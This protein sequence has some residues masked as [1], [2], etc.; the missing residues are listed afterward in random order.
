MPVQW[1]ARHNGAERLFTGKKHAVPVHRLKTLPKQNNYTDCGLFL[2]AYLQYFAFSLPAKEQDLHQLLEHTTSG[3][4]PAADRALEGNLLVGQGVATLLTKCREACDVMSASNQA[5]HSQSNGIPWMQLFWHSF[6]L[7]WPHGR[8]LM[9]VCVLPRCHQ[10][11]VNSIH[12]GML[13]ICKQQPHRQR[14][15]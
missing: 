1:A 9:V 7:P 10:S 12:L 2:L 6:N 4:Q 15:P 8:I 3:T 14:E 5:V 13:A 11:I